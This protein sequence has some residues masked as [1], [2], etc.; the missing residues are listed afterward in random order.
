MS[1]QEV[2]GFLNRMF[3]ETPQEKACIEKGTTIGLQ[4][5]TMGH[6]AF[7]KSS[8]NTVTGNRPDRQRVATSDSVTCDH[9]VHVH[10]NISLHYT[11]RTAARVVS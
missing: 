8:N 9:A 2:V 3:Y 11:L 5:Q 6:R 4:Y 1:L 10:Q 7:R